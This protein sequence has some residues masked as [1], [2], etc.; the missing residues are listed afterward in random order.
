MCERA[1]LAVVCL[2][3]LLMTSSS[4][5]ILLRQF[6]SVPVTKRNL[7]TYQDQLLVC[8]CL[9]GVWLQVMRPCNVCQTLRQF[10]QCGMTLVNMHLGPPPPLLALLYFILLY[11]VVGMGLNLLTCLSA[12]RVFILQMVNI[13]LKFEP[14]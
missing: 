3:M 12:T 6:S 2:V 5:A 1:R 14:N 10:I 11:G 8:I 7:V 9:I 13:S 4:S